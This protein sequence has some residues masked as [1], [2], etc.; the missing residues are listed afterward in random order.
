M[1]AMHSEIKTPLPLSPPSL[2]I[3]C[4]LVGRLENLDLDPSH[5][6]TLR[7]CNIIYYILYTIYWG[8]EGCPSWMYLHWESDQILWT[9]LLNPGG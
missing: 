1:I 7:S 5:I 4:S 2:L 9:P 3:V 8:R 6:M